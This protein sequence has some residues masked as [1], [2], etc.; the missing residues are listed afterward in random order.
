VIVGVQTNTNKSSLSHLEHDLCICICSAQRVC[1]YR[2]RLDVHMCHYRGAWLAILIPSLPTVFWYHFLLWCFLSLRCIL[3]HHKTY[4][5]EGMV[6][7]I[8]TLLIAVKPPFHQHWNDISTH[9]IYGIDGLFN[10]WNS[11]WCVCLYVN[12]QI[13]IHVPVININ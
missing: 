6:S 7:D 3:L 10:V 12:L 4:C 1:V 9:S 11:D 13:W 5:L 2:Y 8:L